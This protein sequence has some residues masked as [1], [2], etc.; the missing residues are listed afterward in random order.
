MRSSIDLSQPE[1][2]HIELKFSSACQSP[3]NSQ[4]D[5]CEKYNKNMETNTEKI[6]EI[7]KLEPPKLTDKRSESVTENYIKLP[8]IPKMSIFYFSSQKL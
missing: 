7:T 8:I 1:I 4:Q 6:P 2:K 5:I 3:R